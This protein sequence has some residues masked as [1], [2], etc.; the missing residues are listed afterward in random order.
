[1]GA[2]SLQLKYPEEGIWYCEEMDM[3]IDCFMINTDPKCV[4]RYTEDGSYEV[5]KCYIDYGGGIFI[6]SQDEETMYIKGRFCLEKERFVI[7]LEDETRYIFSR[8][9]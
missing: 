5:C 9:D 4:K 6:L 2:C 7:T 1:M 3:E 8:T